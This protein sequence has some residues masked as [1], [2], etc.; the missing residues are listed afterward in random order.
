MQP[1]VDAARIAAE[2]ATRAANLALLAAAIGG[3]VSIVVTIVNVL[4]ARHLARLNA[5]LADRQSAKNAAREYE[6]DARQRLYKECEPVLFRLSEAAEHAM[7][8]VASLARSSREGRLGPDASSWLAQPEYYMA[9]TVYNLLAPLAVFKLLQERLTFVDL[10]VDAKVQTEYLLAKVMYLAFTEDFELA[11]AGES[12]LYKPFEDEWETL[13]KTSPGVH[14]RQGVALGRLDRAT[15]ALLR[16]A[17]GDQRRVASYGEFEMAVIADL[18]TPDPVYAPFAD[19]FDHFN[20]RTRPVLWRIL[21][22]QA[23]LGRHVLL[24]AR[25]RTNVASTAPVPSMEDLQKWLEP[26]STGSVSEFTRATFTAAQRY[27]EQTHPQL[28]E[29]L[30][31]LAA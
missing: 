31:T 30:K 29:R 6:Y 12:L 8:R 19:I 16:P 1:Q 25:A 18:K 3:A 28:L 26:S 2:A 23:I 20:P 4:T 24:A 5:D 10:G 27:L 7:Y 11:K 17:T 15:E 21:V 14:W 22:L 13:R 9:S